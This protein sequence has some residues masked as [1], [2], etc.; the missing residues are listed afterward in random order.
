MNMLVRINILDRKISGSPSLKYLHSYLWFQAN[1][2]TQMLSVMN[3]KNNLTNIKLSFYNL[4]FVKLSIRYWLLPL[5]A[6]LLMLLLG[7][8]YYQCILTKYLAFLWQD[9]SQYYFDCQY[10]K[11]IRLIFRPLIPIITY[12]QSR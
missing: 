8:Y 10:T 9:E 6:D 11:N 12:W 4:M 7:I 2:P 3:C 1:F 5:I